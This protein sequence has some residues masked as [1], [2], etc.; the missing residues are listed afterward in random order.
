MIY[1]DQFV[2]LSCIT[3]K[4]LIQYRLL[5]SSCAALRLARHF[6]LLKEN[7]S[8]PGEV[9]NYGQLSEQWMQLFFRTRGCSV[10]LEK[11]LK[12]SVALESLQRID[13]KDINPKIS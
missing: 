7:A 4:L 3:D 5:P 2:F 10:R 6:N 12:D 11:Q 13:H 1:S 8:E 9:L